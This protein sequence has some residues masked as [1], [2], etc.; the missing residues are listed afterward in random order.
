LHFNKRRVGRTSLELTELGIGSATIAGMNGTI[1]PPDQARGTISAALDAGVGYFDTAPHYG[2]GSAEHL[3]G[4]ALRFRGPYALSTKVGR[5]LRP[6]RSDAER[7]IESP[8]TEP[9]PFEIVY[10][11]S[12]DGI[13][14][15]YE[16]SQQRLGLA[17]IDILL[18]HDIGTQTHGVDGNKKHW[19]DLTSGGYRALDE[20][21]KKGL[22]SAIG[23]GVNEW[24]VLMD[25]MEIGQ[26]DV[27]LLANRY[28]LIEQTTL[29]PLFTTCL[30]RGTSM[31]A[32]GPFAA[33]VLAGTNV[34]GPTNGAYQ[35]APPE[36]VAKVTALT[37]V[38]NNHGIPLGAAALQ[39]PLA[40]KVVASVL[41][42]PKTPGELK[43]NLD[44]WNTKIPDKFWDDLADRKL[45]AP[46]T[47]LPNGRTAA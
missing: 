18:V 1:V 16:A 25:A 14:R 46:G 41:T 27:F 38:A 32:A 8:W 36:I 29:Q 35:A 17:N 33:G 24:P 11:Y 4:D 6:V 34:W 47:P 21:R 28:N 22:V 45:V 23:L 40:H 9:F 20:L 44:W 26:W 19:A 12:Y 31:I 15:S 39:F 10:D 37:E 7:T 42:G 13:M 43:A 30:E 2:F 5:L 3:V